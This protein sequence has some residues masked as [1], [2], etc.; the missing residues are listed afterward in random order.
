MLEEDFNPDRYI[1]TQEGLFKKSDLG[2][3][4]N[5][6]VR[7][8]T[9]AFNII[10]TIEAFGTERPT[11]KPKIVLFQDGTIRT[12]Y[13]FRGNVGEV[14]LSDQDRRLMLMEINSD[15][16]IYH[17]DPGTLAQSINF[18][19]QKFSYTYSEPVEESTI[20]SVGI[21]NIGDF[22]LSGLIAS[23]SKVVKDQAVL[24]DRDNASVDDRVT[25]FLKG[26][27]NGTK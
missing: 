21:T 16:Y 19:L 13:Q 9:G 2:T 6:H 20:E 14:R 11:K 10:G 25:D 26:K 8:R 12:N 24:M 15:H 5:P 18:A 3:V 22:L 17:I 27:F 4:I 1:L 23:D 7:M